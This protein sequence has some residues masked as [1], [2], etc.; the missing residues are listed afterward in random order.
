MYP[1]LFFVYFR[2]F[3]QTLQSLQQI[4]RYEKCPSI[5]QCWD[6]NPQPSEHE[7]PPITRASAQYWTLLQSKLDRLGWKVLEAV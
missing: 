6:S 1:R 4:N 5:I 2:L 7:S 3:K